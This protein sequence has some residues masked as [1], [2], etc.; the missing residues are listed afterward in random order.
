MWLMILLL[1]GNETTIVPY[2]LSLGWSASPSSIT[3]SC[4]KTQLHHL[5]GVPRQNQGMEKWIMGAES[6]RTSNVRDHVHCEQHKHTMARLRNEQ[7]QSKG[8]GTS[9]YSLNSHRLRFSHMTPAAR[10]SAIRLNRSKT[11]LWGLSTSFLPLR[12]LLGLTM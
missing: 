6:L 12:Q 7:A 3:E 1:S 5:F 2:R 10:P 11:T 8:S 9:S 4:H